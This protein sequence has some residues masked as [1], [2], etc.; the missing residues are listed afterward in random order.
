V[1][2]A[3]NKCERDDTGDVHLGAED[4]HV[5]AELDADSLDVFE[6]LLVVRTGATDPDLD[7]VL[8][9]LGSNLTESADDT[10]ESGGDLLNCISK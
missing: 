7:L 4:M 10:L 9:E 5:K 1:V 6:T 8:D 3:G 2:L